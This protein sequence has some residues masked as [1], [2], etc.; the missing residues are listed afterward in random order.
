MEHRDPGSVQ[1]AR[2]RRRGPR[3]RSRHPRR[4]ASGRM[5]SN[6]AVSRRRL[7][8][9]CMDVVPEAP[10][11]DVQGGGALWAGSA[12]RGMPGSGRAGARRCAP[13][14]PSTR[15]SA[16]TRA[17]SDCC[18]ASRRCVPVEVVRW[19]RAEVH[20]RWVQKRGRFGHCWI[21]RCSW[22]SRRASRTT[23]GTLGRTRSPK[24]VRTSIP[25][26]GT[27][28]KRAVGSAQFSPASGGTSV[29]D[30]PRGRVIGRRGWRDE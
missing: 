17:G 29:G 11:R 13:A 20:Q 22:R 28:R 12:S 15:T 18:R 5:G 9:P 4:R 27:R 16:D 10:R 7:V 8:Q 23:V 30:G 25:L 3:A 19:G 26:L 24:R 6:P 2:Q 14:G 21:M 1:C